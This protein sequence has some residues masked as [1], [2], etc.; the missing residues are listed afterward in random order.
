MKDVRIELATQAKHPT[1]GGV[2]GILSLGF[3]VSDY[4][5]ANR[6][7]AYSGSLI[8]RA[9]SFNSACFER[10]GLSRKQLTGM[11]LL[12]QIFTAGLSIGLGIL[13]GKLAS[14][15]FL[16]FLQ[17]TENVANSV[18]PFRVVFDSKDTNQLYIVVG[19]MML[20][21]RDPAADS[22]P[23]A[24]RTSGGQDGRGALRGA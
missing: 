13:I 16:P 9:V 1:R 11:L 7:Y 21:G 3:F 6:L 12:E 14:I 17:T 20:T 2:F 15:L 8:Y 18:P 10:W 22:Y 23:Q 24:A 5:V 19:C 4:C